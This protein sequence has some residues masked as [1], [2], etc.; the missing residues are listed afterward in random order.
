MG[1]GVLVI[2]KIL[3]V[4]EFFFL[5]LDSLHVPQEYISGTK[6]QTIAVPFLRLC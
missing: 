6:I 4:P 2:L 3:I 5:V 1:V